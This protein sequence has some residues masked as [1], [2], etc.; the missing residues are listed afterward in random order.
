MLHF[1]AFCSEAP[2][3]S[4]HNFIRAR[5]NSVWRSIST[6]RESRRSLDR[7]RRQSRHKDQVA[8]ARHR[9]DGRLPPRQIGRN[10]LSS[11]LEAFR[12][13]QSGTSWRESLHR[14]DPGAGDVRHGPRPRAGTVGSRTGMRV[15]SSCSGPYDRRGAA[16][17]RLDRKRRHTAGQ[18]CSGSRPRPRCRSA[19]TKFRDSRPPPCG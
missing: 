1:I 4:R 2:A 16:A 17:R 15:C 14:R 12:R 7:H 18:S 9:R 5:I 19:R 11:D 10:M 6:R 13:Q 3:V 8:R